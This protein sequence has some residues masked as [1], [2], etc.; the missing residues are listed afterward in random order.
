VLGVTTSAPACD[1]ACEGDDKPGIFGVSA[2]TGD[3]TGLGKLNSQFIVPVPFIRFSAMLDGRLSTLSLSLAPEDDD[4]VDARP[5]CTSSASGS[6][7]AAGVVAPSAAGCSGVGDKGGGVAAFTNDDACAWVTG[8][9]AAPRAG[10]DIDWRTPAPVPAAF[11]VGER[12]EGA[13]DMDCGRRGRRR[14]LRRV[15]VLVNI[16]FRWE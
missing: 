6:S 4:G 16:G 1:S 11:V 14:R 12:D 3:D 9:A 8:D 13:A 5:S 7:T 2:T 15:C 10:G